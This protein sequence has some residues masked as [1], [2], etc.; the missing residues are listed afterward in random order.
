MP[1]RLWQMRNY[2]C[3]SSRVPRPH[4]RCIK[5]HEQSWIFLDDRFGHA[6][7]HLHDGR[8]ILLLPCILKTCSQCFGAKDFEFAFDVLITLKLFEQ[9]TMAKLLQI[10]FLVWVWDEPIALFDP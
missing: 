3:H 6:F 1:N 9:T 4:Y 10:R 2:E 5:V 8:V 7:R